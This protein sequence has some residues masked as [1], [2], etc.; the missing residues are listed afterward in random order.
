MDIFK[1]KTH[2]TILVCTS[3]KVKLFKPKIKYLCSPEK[4]DFELLSGLKCWNFELEHIHF[5]YFQVHCQTLMLFCF[6]HVT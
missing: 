5:V 6:T 4:L 1:V 2:F 3:L